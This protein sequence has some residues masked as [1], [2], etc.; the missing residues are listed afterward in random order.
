[1]GHTELASGSMI[2]GA[3]TSRWDSGNARTEKDRN[4]SMLV[5]V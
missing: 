4:T 1:M 2:F 3:I 5:N